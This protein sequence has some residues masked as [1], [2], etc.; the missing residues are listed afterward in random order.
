MK[1]FTW[2]FYY[3]HALHTFGKMG[4]C[5][6]EWINGEWVNWEQGGEKLFKS[7]ELFY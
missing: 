1:N 6:E 4:G 5:E 7:E 2:K 3:I